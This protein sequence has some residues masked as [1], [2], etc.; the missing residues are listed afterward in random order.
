ME[1]EKTTR[2][3]RRQTL[4]KL[5]LGHLIAVVHHQSPPRSAEKF[6]VW[7]CHPGGGFVA[8]GGFIVGQE[9]RLRSEWPSE[10]VCAKVALALDALAYQSCAIGDLDDVTVAGA[11]GDVE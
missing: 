7:H 6:E 2:A 10:E 8:G 5:V 4:A 11:L 3:Q 9:V 1:F